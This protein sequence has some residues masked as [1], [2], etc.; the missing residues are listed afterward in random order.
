MTYITSSKEYLHTHVAKHEIPVTI[1]AVKTGNKLISPDPEI[2]LYLGQMTNIPFGTPLTRQ[3][4]QGGKYYEI[5]GGITAFNKDV[6]FISPIGKT[7][8]FAFNEKK[9]LCV[10][11]EMAFNYYKGKQILI[12]AIIPKN[13]TYMINEDG[14]Y[15]SSSIMPTS[16][17]E[18]EYTT[19]EDIL[20]TLNQLNEQCPAAFDI[21]NT[22]DFTGT[23]V[24]EV[25]N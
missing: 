10:F 3:D 21:A 6:R 12:N 23:F 9:L 24:H 7:A 1:L 17:M 8:T 22:G 4:N 16:I 11:S 15:V 25:L 14:I 5:A 18:V 2:E 20:N 19:I 13:A